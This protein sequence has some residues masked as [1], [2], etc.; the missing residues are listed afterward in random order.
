[1]NCTNDKVTNYS[2]IKLL[3]LLGLITLLTGMMLLI[4][5]VVVVVLGMGVQLYLERP[6]RRTEMYDISAAAVQK[7]GFPTSDEFLE[8]FARRYMAECESHKLPIPNLTVR[9]NML[10]FAH[11]LY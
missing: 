1:M 2:I 8:P 6:T 10:C 9:T 7:A 3:A 5:G 4:P 11:L